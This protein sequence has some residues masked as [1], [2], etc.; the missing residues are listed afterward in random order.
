MQK[1]ANININ[2]R[3]IDTPVGLTVTISY[4]L[5]SEENFQ[6]KESVTAFDIEVPA[7]NENLKTIG[8]LHDLNSFFAL[9]SEHFG[10]AMPATISFPSHDQELF[11]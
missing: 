10:N 5:E 7:T 4:S 8:S 3:D 11:R 1:K 2:G 6:K 9:D